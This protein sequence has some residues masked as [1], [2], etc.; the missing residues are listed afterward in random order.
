MAYTKMRI[1]QT[2]RYGRIG[3]GVRF[4][5]LTSSCE[6]FSKP[7]TGHGDELKTVKIKISCIR[8]RSADGSDPDWEFLE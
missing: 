2:Q 5:A 1:I 4:L 3:Y 7:N 8:A 6:D